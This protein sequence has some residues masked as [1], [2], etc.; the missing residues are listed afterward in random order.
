MRRIQTCLP[1]FLLLLIVAGSGSG[2]GRP[3]SSAAVRLAHPEA[4]ERLAA[5]RELDLHPDPMA[6]RPLLRAAFGDPDGRVRQEAALALEAARGQGDSLERLALEELARNRDL[7]L[8]GWLLDSR[9]DGVRCGALSVL[10]SMRTQGAW[11]CVADR[12]GREPSAGVRLLCARVLA[13]GLDCGAGPV[14]GRLTETLGLGLGDPELS[15]RGVCAKALALAGEPRAAGVLA[16]ALG[17]ASQVERQELL[18]LL[19]VA[20]GEDLGQDPAPWI[21]RFGGT[22]A[23]GA[24]EAVE[25]AEEGKGGPSC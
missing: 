2:C 10:Q 24:V 25:E 14:Q 17:E 22:A 13:Q 18:E 1:G 11:V 9:L 6:L 15:V 23:T 5:V 8:A 16:E 21:R 7:P 12:M 3:V 4:G 20:T 19:R